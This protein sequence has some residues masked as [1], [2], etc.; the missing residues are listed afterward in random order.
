MLECCCVLGAPERGICNSY[1]AVRQFDDATSLLFYGGGGG[2][3][4][5]N[6]KNHSGLSRDIVVHNLY[7]PPGTRSQNR[8]SGLKATKM[9]GY[10]EI[11]VCKLFAVG[12]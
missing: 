3:R 7:E 1:M 8:A 9:R 5:Q 6:C 10:S 2:G 12:E 4:T 11:S